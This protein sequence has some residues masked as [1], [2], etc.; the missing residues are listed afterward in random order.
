MA[1]IKNGVPK[2]LLFDNPIIEFPKSFG[3]MKRDFL[4]IT[5]FYAGMNFFSFFLEFGKNQIISAEEGSSTWHIIIGI[6]F[7]ALYFI[8]G[9]LSKTFDIWINAIEINN[10]EA[11]T[12]EINNVCIKLLSILQG[13]VFKKNEDANVLESMSE[14]TFLDSSRGYVSTLWRYQITFVSRIVEI[15]ILI[16]MFIGFGKVS[17]SSFL[18]TVIL[19]ISFMVFVMAKKRIAFYKSQREKTKK[20]EQEKND[21]QNDILNIRPVNQKHTDLMVSRI[22]NVFAEKFRLVRFKNK[23]G[24]QYSLIESLFLITAVIAIMIYEYV[25]KT[26]DSVWVL[27]IVSILTIF[28]SI[29]NSLKNVV[30]RIERMCTAIKDIETYYPDM[31]LILEQYEIESVTEKYGHPAIVKS[32]TIPKSVIS[33]KQKGKEI[34]YSLIIPYDFTFFPGDTVF[35]TGPTGCGKSTTL[36]A[37]SG[38]MKFSDFEV[39]YEL[40]ENGDIENEFFE[41][42]ARMGSGDMLSELVFGD[43]FD[44]EKLQYLFDNLHITEFLQDRANEE[45]IFEYLKKVK[46]K[47]FSHGQRQRLLLARN[48]YHL[49]GESVTV[50]IDEATSGLNDEICLDV[51]KFIKNYCKGKILFL[52]SHQKQLTESVCNKRITYHEVESKYEANLEILNK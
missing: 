38:R 9:S 43:E 26:I 47:D 16:L 36:R 27:S 23:K 44:E 50:C 46:F 14:N 2:R 40:L 25:G 31:S 39:K 21:W 32:I 6:M 19:L 11:M 15:S 51:L 18:I 45:T 41:T 37:I 3:K 13:K 12:S 28:S 5:L 17:F 52:A 22:V 33:Y 49:S 7:I 30:D 34:P 24:N 10:D 1:H 42:D 4:F 20:I 8:K 48:L 29:I 35:V